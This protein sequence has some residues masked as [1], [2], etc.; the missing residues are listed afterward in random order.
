M[1]QRYIKFSNYARTNKNLEVRKLEKLRNS[2]C[3]EKVLKFSVYNTEIDFY[4]FCRM[5]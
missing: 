3:R 2:I 4:F 5:S 1:G